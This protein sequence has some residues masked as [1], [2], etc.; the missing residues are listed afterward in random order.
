MDCWENSII[1]NGIGYQVL[2]IACVTNTHHCHHRWLLIKIK[3]KNK[4][5]NKK[6]NQEKDSLPAYLSKEFKLESN[7]I[8][9]NNLGEMGM[10]QYLA[11]KMI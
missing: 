3:N 7:T 11:H 1:C 2:Q 4:K 6:K 9:L 10:K 8:N 5:I